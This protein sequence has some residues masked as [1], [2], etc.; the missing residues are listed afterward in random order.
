MIKSLISSL[1]TT[2]MR[3]LRVPGDWGSEVLQRRAEALHIIHIFVF[4]AGIPYALAP[5]WLIAGQW[6]F[7]YFTIFISAVGSVLLRRKYLKLS[8]IWTIGLLWLMFTVGSVTE[9]GVISSSFAGSVVIIMF[10]GFTFGVRLVAALSVMTIAV[11]TTMVILNHNGLLPPPAIVYTD[12]NI[13]ADFTFY[14][15]ITGIITGFAIR[16]IDRSARQSEIELEERKNAESRLL[17]SQSRLKALSDATFEGLGISE[18]GTIID[19]NE[20]LTAMSGYT[21]DE[22]I[23]QP[24][25]KLA[26]PDDVLYVRSQMVFSEAGPYTHRMVRKDGSIFLVEVRSR[27]FMYHGRV[28]R[29]AAVRDITERTNADLE[30][31]RLEEQL[32]QSQKMEAVGRLAG[33][34]AHDFNNLLSAILGYSEL[35]MKKIPEDS[36]LHSKVRQIHR[37]GERAASLTRQLLAFS[38]KQTLEMKPIALKA[39]VE[40]L[41][42]LLHRLLG[43]DIQLIT[44]VSPGTWHVRGDKTQIEQILINLAVNSRDAMPN[45]G[46][47]VVRSSNVTIDGENQSL[48]E[49]V[50]PGDYVLMTVIDVGIGMDEQTMQNMFEPFYTTKPVGKGTGLGLSTVYGIVKQHEGV[51]SVTSAPGKGTTFKVL[52]PRSLNTDLHTAHESISVT[53]SRSA[54]AVLL[55]ED[56]ESVRDYTKEV[57]SSGGYAVVAAAS[58][59]E[60]L[61]VVHNGS[62]SPLLLV[63]DV[64]MPSMNGKELY[65]LL[66]QRLPQLKVLYISGYP[67]NVIADRGILEEGA[68]LL[69]KPFSSHVLLNKVSALLAG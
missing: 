66:K 20:Q 19:V 5:S 68:F 31:M 52:L 40:D 30:R 58:P 44:E 63:T 37:S 15:I 51:I 25:V 41:S 61:D 34:I 18:N 38:R 54:E 8:G 67:A 50:P 3:L 6:A 49:D 21:A 16:R 36:P 42:L 7:V 12:I 47:L 23:G 29:M 10:A 26:H 14:I 65:L 1:P 33:G 56:E 4:I 22:L 59:Q 35:L 9:G 13:L 39:L 2:L 60:A 53:P 55:V 27:Q 17:A 69:P 64:I 11:G 45:G 46:S 48:Y 24:V 57:L 28:A 62:F 32:R 43:E